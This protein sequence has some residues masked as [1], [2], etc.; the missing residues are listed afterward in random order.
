MDQIIVSVAVVT[1]R[2]N[3]FVDSIRHVLV[4]AT[5]Q[6]IALLAITFTGNN[7]SGDM[8]MT[9]SMFD[10]L[11]VLYFTYLIYTF[12]FSFVLID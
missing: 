5:P 2:P 12:S 4:I 7:P 3:V 11:L 9:P 1:P 10:S 8:E 6:D